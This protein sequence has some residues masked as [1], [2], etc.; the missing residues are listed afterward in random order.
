MPELLKLGV[1]AETELIANTAYSYRIKPGAVVLPG[2]EPCGVSMEA[3]SATE[4]GAPY[5]YDFSFGY[6]DV[7]F[8]NI[9][10]THAAGEQFMIKVVKDEL[11]GLASPDSGK[12]GGSKV[13]QMMKRPIPAK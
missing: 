12:W 7:D 11:G 9:A 6:G 13:R 4:G 3:W 8:Y 1:P 10:E 5:L 2:T